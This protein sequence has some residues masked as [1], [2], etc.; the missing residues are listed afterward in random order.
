MVQAVGIQTTLPATLHAGGRV[1]Q[2]VDEEMGI[3][4]TAGWNH[5]SWHSQPQPSPGA[6]APVPLKSAVKPSST[7]A[8]ALQHLKVHA[9]AQSLQPMA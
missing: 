8:V 2:S 3:N 6:L 9:P 5:S 7:K 4:A 1:L